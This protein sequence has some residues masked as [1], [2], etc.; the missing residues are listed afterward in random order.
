MA[1]LSP[2]K[3]DCCFIDVLGAGI[4]YLPDSLPPCLTPRPVHS[5]TRCRN[6]CLMLR[7]RPWLSAGSD[8]S[9]SAVPG[10]E[11]GLVKGQDSA[12]CWEAWPVSS[13]HGSSLGR[14]RW[15]R[16]RVTWRGV[17][18]SAPQAQLNSE[19][20]EQVEIASRGFSDNQ[21]CEKM[22]KCWSC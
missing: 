8:S 17:D 1:S 13:A 19:S 16:G 7:S 22:I 3:P 21:C 15:L 12:S 18:G 2:L 20:G 14:R 6:A 5:Q 9:R 11:V 4:T 10:L